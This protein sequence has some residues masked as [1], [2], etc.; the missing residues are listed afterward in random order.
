MARL[1]KP[2]SL[3]RTVAD[4]PG[5]DRRYAMAGDKVA[6]LGWSNQVPFEDGIAQTVDW[7]VANEAWWLA[8]KSGEWDAW[9]RRQYADRLAGSSAAEPSDA[10]A[11]APPA[12]AD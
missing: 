11:V 12:V 10:G 6:A 8:V 9:Y 3:V 1:G 7:Y 2:W 4:R 5:H